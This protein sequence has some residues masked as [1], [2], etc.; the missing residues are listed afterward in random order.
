MWR[1]VGVQVELQQQETNTMFDRLEEK[2]FQ[3]VLAGWSVALSPDLASLWGRESPFNFTSYDNPRTFALFE[4]AQRTT[5]EAEANALWKQAASQI[6]ADRPYTWLYF[7]DG[8]VGVRDRLR[9]VRVDTYGAY[10]NTWE[11]W[12]TDGQGRGAAGDS[13]RDTTKG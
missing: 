3:A 2:D 11:W 7:L 5:T 12:V 1:R 13:A 9:G 8:I 6:I 4:Q 10:Q